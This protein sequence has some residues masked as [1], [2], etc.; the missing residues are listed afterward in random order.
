MVVIDLPHPRTGLR[1]SFPGYFFPITN[2]PAERMGAW[3]LLG[4]Y[5]SP[6][7]FEDRLCEFHPCVGNG[8]SAAP[9]EANEASLLSKLLPFNLAGAIRGQLQD[10][11]GT[12]CDPKRVQRTVL[13]TSATGAGHSG[14]LLLAVSR[15]AGVLSGRVVRRVGSWWRDASCGREAVRRRRAPH[16]RCWIPPQPHAHLSLALPG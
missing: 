16:G 4:H 6:G 9:F 12:A 15:A 2:W 7:T 10:A 3:A 11:S 13:K 8:L 14:R 5:R 1:Q